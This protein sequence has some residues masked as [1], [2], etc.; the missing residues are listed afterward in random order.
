M[1][2][3]LSVKVL[4]LLFGWRN[5]FS[6]L[7]GVV[8]VLKDLALASL[9]IAGYLLAAGARLLGKGFVACC[10][11]PAAFSVVLAAFIAGRVLYPDGLSGPVVKSPFKAKAATERTVAKPKAKTKAPTPAAKDTFCSLTGIC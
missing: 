9:E 7:G 5:W 6:W 4:G 8:P 1:I 11:N 10:S 3:S 2:W